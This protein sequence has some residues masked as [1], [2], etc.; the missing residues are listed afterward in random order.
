MLSDMIQDLKQTI[1]EAQTLRKAGKPYKAE[2]DKAVRIVK[3]LEILGMDLIT[4]K[5]II[6]E[7]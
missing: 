6:N 4:I 5:A 3:E 2:Q 7:V 1:K